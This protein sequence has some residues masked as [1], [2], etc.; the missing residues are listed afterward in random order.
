MNLGPSDYKTLV[1]RTLVPVLVCRVGNNFCSWDTPQSLRGNYILTWVRYSS[2]KLVNPWISVFKVF[3]VCENEPH[4]LR[5]FT[6]QLMAKQDCVLTF[7]ISVFTLSAWYLCMFSVNSQK[8]FPVDSPSK[9]NH[10]HQFQLYA[11]DTLCKSIKYIL[12][13]SF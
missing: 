8:R 4:R 10:C 7:S 12:G 6:F 2:P 1:Q 13:P 11:T 9:G 3:M 5:S